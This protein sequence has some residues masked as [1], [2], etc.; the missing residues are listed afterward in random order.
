MRNFKD[1]LRSG[2]N[3]STIVEVDA[4]LIGE[5]MA[6]QEPASKE[7]IES[8]KARARVVAEGEW[9]CAGLTSP[10]ASFQEQASASFQRDIL[11]RI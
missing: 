3:V 7:L 5:S 8:W 4:A 2:H 1:V 11:V 10:F 9:R 6:R